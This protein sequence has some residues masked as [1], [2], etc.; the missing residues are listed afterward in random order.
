MGRV[1]TSAL[2]NEMRESECWKEVQ[3]ILRQRL[4][5]CRTELEIPSKTPEETAYARGEC[6]TIRYILDSLMTTYETLL[7]EK[8]KAEEKRKAK[9]KENA[10]AESTEDS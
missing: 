8:E 9:E 4:E 3:D 1:I 2:W 6:A 10:K 7:I 5:I